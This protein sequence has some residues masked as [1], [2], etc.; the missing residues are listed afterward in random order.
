MIIGQRPP[1]SLVIVPLTI[2]EQVIGA[3]SVQSEQVGAYTEQDLNFLTS[4]ASQVAVAVENARLYEQERRRATQAALLTTVAQ[5]TNAILSA[6]RL[7]P[8]VVEAIHE[9]FEYDSVILMLVDPEERVL[10][11]G[12]KAGVGT[13]GLPDDFRQSFDQGIIGWVAR[14]GETLLV[15]DTSQDERYFAPIPDLHVAGSELA[16]PLKIGGETI[17]VLDLQCVKTHGFDEMDV[18]T[19]QTLA[20]QVAVALHNAQLYEEARRRAE[21]LAALNA[22][23]A[24]LGQSLE[25]EEVLDVAM[26]EVTRVLGVEASAVS[27]VDEEEDVLI[28]KAQRGLRHSHVGMR[29]PL[30][31]GLSGIVI[32]SGKPLVTGDVSQDP[33]LAVPAFAREGIQAMALVP[34]HSR[35]QVVGV[36]SAMSHAPH[37]FDEREIALLEGIANQVGAAVENARLFE[38]ERSQRQTAETLRSVATILTSSLELEQVLDWLLDHLERL[39]P[40]DRATVMLLKEGQ[41]QVVAAHGYTRRPNGEP[42]V[43]YTV[44]LAEDSLLQQ[45]V[46]GGKPVAVL[47]PAT[48]SRWWYKET[49]WHTESWIGVPLTVRDTVIGIL[50]VAREKPPRFRQ[51]DAALVA[52]IAGQAAVAIENAHLYEEARR[53]TRELAAMY[54]V[55][56]TVGRSLD[57]SFVLSETL[58]HVT[59][60]VGLQAGAIFLR[61]K[62]T[63]WMTLSAHRRLPEGASERLQTILLGE[64][65]LGR[66]AQRAE[67]TRL[68]VWEIFCG[69]EE[70]GGGKASGVVVPL[71]VRGRVIGAMAL[72]APNADEIPPATVRLLDAVARH[73]AVAIENARLY[74]EMETREKMARALYQ[75][76]RQLTSLDPRQIPE[77]VLGELQQVVAYDVAGVLIK[78]DSNVDLMLHVA[79]PCSQAELREAEDRL[80]EG[81]RLLGGGPLRPEEV[82]RSVWSQVKVGP[83]SAG[84]PGFRSYLSAPLVVGERLAG[85][86]QL[87]SRQDEAYDEQAQRLVLTVANQVATAVENAQLYQ[88]VREHATN[89]E[90]AYKQLQEV[91]KLKDELIQNVSHELRT[92]L[93]FV[94]G[95]VQ[96]MREG[97]LGPLTEDQ[98]KALEV[99]ARKTDHL[100]RLVSDIV[101]LETVSRETL[102][103]KP[104][105][106]GQLAQMALDGCRPAA[107]EAGIELRAEIPEELPP[108][109][110][111]WARISEVFD[112]LLANAIKF[113]PDGGT[114]TIRIKEQQNK[115]RVEVS[116]TGI[117]IPREKLNRVFDRFYQV[118]GSTRRRFGGAGLGLAIVKRIVESHGG[119]VGVESKLG[120]GSTFH[121]TLPKAS[122]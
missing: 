51:R 44:P 109:L 33:R 29:V 50:T 119:E 11:I 67:V 48:D 7:L 107:L 102:D 2:G 84:G 14:H 27:L 6:E 55:A 105:D 30:G 17:G 66:A 103:I 36:L 93:T 121:F 18:A 72:G 60:L 117:G 88:A 39:V 114:I 25:L 110:A 78:W 56:T 47:D 95:Y 46:R 24:R 87:S 73:L 54:R 10:K 71:R 57:L 37:N 92:P 38:A 76:T 91:D 53:Q 8:A 75:V 40:H 99:M 13:E 69:K 43:G 34:M 89:L 9:H 79:T 77:R 81:F 21:E 20:E 116:D 122:L 106:L 85:L 15:S 98:R 115:L 16:V 5:Q 86:L 104:I 65:P 3:L 94:K 100:A 4:V 70:E 19:A 61:E 64:G 82:N 112:N 96:L 120:E 68:P 35:G 62:G 80:L 63:H 31:E 97:E 58:V 41:L 101:T 22:V 32:R 45:V 111:D 26:E 49:L 108:V 59:D 12:G 74:A 83:D 52:D 28:L 23:A 118:D 42:V 1:R 90:E 113:S